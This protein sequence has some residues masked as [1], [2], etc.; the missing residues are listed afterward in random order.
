M[1]SPAFVNMVETDEN[2]TYEEADDVITDDADYMM[3]F[4][5][6][7][8]EGYD[9]Y[10]LE[11][12]NIHIPVRKISAMYDLLCSYD[13]TSSVYRAIIALSSC[14]KQVSFVTSPRNVIGYYREDYG[15]VEVSWEVN[16]SVAKYQLYKWDEEAQWDV[17]PYT[18]I[19][20]TSYVFNYDGGFTEGRYRI[21]AISNGET[22][23]VSEEFTLSWQQEQPISL[24]IRIDV[25]DA[26]G[27]KEPVDL[28]E[29]YPE[30]EQFSF[31]DEYIFPVNQ[32]VDDETGLPAEHFEH[33]KKY[34]YALCAIANDGYYFDIFAIHNDNGF[35]VPD[36]I[37]AYGIDWDKVSNDVYEGKEYIA[38]FSFTYDEEIGIPAEKKE[39]LYELVFDA[40]E[41]V[42]MDSPKPIPDELFAH[43]GLTICGKDCDCNVTPEF[44]KQNANVWLSM[45]ANAPAESFT[46]NEAYVYVVYFHVNDGWDV[47]G[48]TDVFDFIMS[49]SC[50][51]TVEVAY[52]D[53]YRVLAVRLGFI[54]AESGKIDAGEHTCSKE[55]VDLVSPSC[56]D[57]GCIAHYACACGKT[58]F[59]RW[60]MHEIADIST[61]GK[62]EPSGHTFGDLW[63]SDGTLH[64]KEC[65][66]GEK[67]GMGAHFDTD[68][69]GKCDTCEYQMPENDPVGSTHEP[70]KNNNVDS[71]IGIVIGVS[72][73]AVIVLGIVV[74]DIIWFVIKKKSIADL[75]AIFKKK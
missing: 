51:E 29:F 62:I 27:S 61:E 54:C 24:P 21:E 40:S 2:G 56:T 67:E 31:S 57:D 45:S 68:N 71:N 58:Y 26:V 53:E 8:K 33:G 19:H 6:K 13:E 43:E 49:D 47:P 9:L 20:G 50:I 46:P 28:S 11:G 42:G 32:C 3:M 39:L 34:S 64:W 73:A 7:A 72:V 63:K 37:R 74:F 16:G 59:D 66:C 38:V 41:L 4:L 44:A 15:S 25:G 48:N 23:A 35:I 65:V 18:D 12:K 5:F 60:G 75:V 70:Y 55:F 30:S 22:V 14:A 36:A 1:G 69:N 52:N 10:N 17:M